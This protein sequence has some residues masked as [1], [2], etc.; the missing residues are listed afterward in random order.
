VIQIARGASER[1]R[2][3]NQIKNLFCR[4]R[5]VDDGFLL[6]NRFGILISQLKPTLQAFPLRGMPTL[7]II[8]EKQRFALRDS[9]LRHVVQ[10]QEHLTVL[11]A[12]ASLATAATTQLILQIGFQ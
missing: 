1:T 4:V 5:V 2:V 6:I 12:D 7:G 11:T 10:N 3:T 9:R 8:P